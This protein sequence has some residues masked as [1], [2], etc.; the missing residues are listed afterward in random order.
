MFNPSW[1]SGNTVSTGYNISY[2]KN[3][4]TCWAMVMLKTGSGYTD[5]YAEYPNGSECHTCRVNCGAT[6]YTSG[7]HGSGATYTAGSIAPLCVCSGYAG[8]TKFRFRFQ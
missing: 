7:G 1:V 3:A 8:A 5:V 4:R 6:S 2:V